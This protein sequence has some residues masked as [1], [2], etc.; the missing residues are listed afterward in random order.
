MSTFPLAPLVTQRNVQQNLNRFVVFSPKTTGAMGR[1]VKIDKELFLLFYC[2]V[3]IKSYDG[4]L[5]VRQIEALRTVPTQSRIPQRTGSSQRHVQQMANLRNSFEHLLMVKNVQVF[6]RVEQQPG[7]KAPTVYITD[8]RVMFRDRNEAPGLYQS[9][10]ARFGIARSQKAKSLS[11]EGRTVYINGQSRSVEEAFKIGRQDTKKNDLALFYSPAAVARDLNIWRQNTLNRITQDTIKELQQVLAHNQNAKTDIN[12][13][14]AGEGAALLGK[15]L[16]GILGELKNHSFKFV[17][18]LA[19]MPELINTLQDKKAA[20]S[21]DFYTA[22][23]DSARMV[24]ANVQN[25]LQ[26]S[27][28]NFTRPKGVET[29]SHR[30]T[31]ASI[32]NLGNAKRFVL[33]RKVDLNKLNATFTQILGT[34][35]GIK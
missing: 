27:I 10:K 2:Q 9:T 4:Q 23:S 13:V 29:T 26:A 32:E 17:E 3:D 33:D 1:A 18:P 8:L 6:Y 30:Y 21:S 34:I 14:V 12:W 35:R 19:N 5:I 15:A 7:D 31:L 16:Q 20:L 24:I 28:A 22:E 11:V 25:A